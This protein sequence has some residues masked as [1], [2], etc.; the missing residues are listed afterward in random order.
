SSSSAPACLRRFNNLSQIQ[1]TDMDSIF[2]EKRQIVSRRDS[3]EHQQEE[4]EE[5]RD[6]LGESET[7]THSHTHTKTNLR[8]TQLS[9]NSSSI[10]THSLLLLLL[11]ERRENFYR[12][13]NRRK[14]PYTH[15]PPCI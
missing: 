11:A 15:C 2:K 6:F 3:N 13:L 7:R 12:D 9:T 4:E 8:C 10:H 1:F 5:R 14:C